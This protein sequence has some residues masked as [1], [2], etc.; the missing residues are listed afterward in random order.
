MKISYNWLKQYLNIQLPAN[1]VAEVLTSIGLEVEG[2]ESFESIKGGLKNVVIG[3][4]VT[5]EKHPDADKLKVTTVNVGTTEKLQIVCGAPNVAAGQKVIVAL[6]GA[7]LY[8][9]S[10]SEAI[11]IKKAK[12]RGV[13]SAGMICAEDELGIGE[14]HAGILVL[15]DSVVV[16]STAADHFRIENDTIFEIGLTPNRS[17]AFSHIGVA[18]DLKAALNAR[19]NTALVLQKPDLSAFKIND[20]SHEVLVSIEDAIACPR[21]SGVTVSGIEV[22]ESP[23]W[24]INKLN[25]IGVRSI[26]NIVDITNYVLHEYG[27]PLHAFDAAK[28]GGNKV[29]VRKAKDNERFVTLDG[30]ERKLTS[31][32]LMICD[33]QKPMCIAG[34]F[35]GS[36]SGVTDNTKTIFIESAYFSPS[37]IRKTATHH[38]LRTDA[39]MHYE[40]GCDPNITIAALQ[41]AVLLIQ[42]LAGGVVSSSVSDFYPVQIFP[43]QVTVKFDYIQ[44]LAGFHLEKASIKKIIHE[45][46][47]DIDTENDTSLIVSVPTFK[48]EVTRPADIVEEIIRIYGYNNFPLPSKLNTSLVL[49]ANIDAVKYENIAA[50]LLNGMGFSEITTNSVSQSKFEQDELLQKQQV[51]LMNSQT[52]ELDCMRTSMLYGML[53]VVAYNQNRKSADLKFFEFGKTYHKTENQ[54]QEYKHL[55]VLLT[56]SYEGGNWLAPSRKTDFYNLKQTIENLLSR[57]GVHNFSIHPTEQ[58]P[59]SYGY[60]VMVSDAQVAIGGLVNATICKQ[61]DIKQ[62][63]WFADINWDYILE[64]GKRNKTEFKQL[65]KFPSVRRDL[66]LVVDKD[67]SF[68]NIE[69]LSQKEAKKL[70]KEVSLF[71]VYTGDKIEK[72]K[73]SY[74]VSFIFQHEEKT[75]TD[76]EIEK[77]MNKLMSS[78]EKDFGALIRK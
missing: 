43:K 59:Y 60:K 63:V 72:G 38:G 35:G 1:E 18:R 78:F 7:S 2:F 51:K 74:A 20:N 48:T 77:V 23:Q 6:V 66:A 28:I 54:H 76:D 26:N 42:E 13:E 19:D 25:A 34:V 22:K 29:V 73:K 17:D 62:E 11:Q 9:T 36:E 49:S 3:E 50:T 46:E 57:L 44:K 31:N 32:D 41:R 71:D 55:A 56:G 75:L 52:S 33:A 58:T 53:D 64:V 30:V 65:P 37:G 24:L 67:L 10:S 61:F 15:P 70:L 45:L 12:I 8:P 27:Q 69:Q 40:K 16:G 4:V 21:Y 68:A 5:C 39:A 14:S 47:I